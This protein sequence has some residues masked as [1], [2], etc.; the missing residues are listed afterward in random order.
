MPRL[1]ITGSRD[2]PDEALIA[3][4]LSRAVEHLGSWETV[5]VHGA[6]PGA[7]SMAAAVFAANGLPVEAHPADWGVHSENC[8]SEDPGTGSC[9]RGRDRC[10]RAG[11]RRNQAMVDA[12]ADL[13]LAFIARRSRGAT[14]CAQ[15][16][17]RAGIPV[18]RFEL[19]DGYPHCFPDRR[20]HT[21]PHRG[22]ILR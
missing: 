11:Y 19:P 4:A 17:E 15:I 6:A 16:A 9:H 7:D 22:C 21:M 18:W 2:W 10:R 13:C 1:L 3:S 12:G 20:V 14:M 8:P 5:L